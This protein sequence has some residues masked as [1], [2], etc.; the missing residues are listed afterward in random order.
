MLS[1]IGWLFLLDS[2]YSVVNWTLGRLHVDNALVWLLG[3]VHLEEGRAE[4][5]AL[6]FIAPMDTPGKKLICR[7]SYEADARSPWE[8]PLS[9]RFDENDSVVVFDDAFIPWENVISHNHMSAGMP[10]LLMTCWSA[11]AIVDAFPASR[12]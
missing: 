10:Y 5:Y 1:T 4:D 3:A 11:C 12:V 8:S 2:L 6:V 9:S 7:R